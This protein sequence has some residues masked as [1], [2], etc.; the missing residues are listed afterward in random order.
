MCVVQ[1]HFEITIAG[2]HACLS[3]VQC[4]RIVY[5]NAVSVGSYDSFPLLLILLH[6]YFIW[7]SGLFYYY[8]TTKWC[9]ILGNIVGTCNLYCGTIVDT[10]VT[11]LYV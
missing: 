6:D 11:L 2:L 5:F 7:S 9:C 4:M 10:K 1:N 3:N 8:L